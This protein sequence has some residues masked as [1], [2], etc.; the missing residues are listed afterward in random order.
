MV[1]IHDRYDLES[2]WPMLRRLI[3]RAIGS[4]VHVAIASIDEDGAPHAT[5]VGSFMLGKEVGR[6][7]YFERFVR[8]LPENVE[9]NPTVSILA[10]DSGKLFWLR[11]LAGGRFIHPP[12]VRLV[13]RASPRAR[14]STRAER[15]RWE[16]RVR[17]FRWLP[18]YTH[19]W[20]GI[21]RV[22]DIEIVAVKPLRLGKM[23]APST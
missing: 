9:R 13:G 12:G 7:L 3:N 10:V 19:L 5:P 2:Q 21:H 22:R 18:G 1:A 16:R 23:E 8:G 11:S 15:Q 20:R 14:E 4:S 17:F 6:A